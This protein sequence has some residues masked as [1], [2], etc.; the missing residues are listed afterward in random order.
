MFYFVQRSLLTLFQE[1]S[2]SGA[3]ISWSTFP[4]YPAC[5][6]IDLNKYWNMREIAPYLIEIKVA[7]LENLALSL[8]LED[9]ETMLLKRTLKSQI[10][11]YDGT[12]IDVDDLNSPLF[13]NLYL[14]YHQTINIEDCEVYPNKHFFSFKEC[15]EEFVYR[16]MKNTYKIMPFWAAKTLDE[17]TKQ[18]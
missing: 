9:R 7:K 10:M 16:E 2:I 18:V 4:S 11:D 8:K 1:K 5:Q 17:V 15:D 14:K 3:N 13:I 12:P 6:V